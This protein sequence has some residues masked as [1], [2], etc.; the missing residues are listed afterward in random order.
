MLWPSWVRSIED[1]PVDLVGAIDHA[2]MILRWRENLRPGELPPKW[3]WHLD[4][5]LEVWFLEVDRIRQTGGSMEGD[6]SESKGTGNEWAPG[7]TIVA[8]PE[9]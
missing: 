8:E 6:G 2:I 5:E 4:W 7:E 3:M 9:S 1:M